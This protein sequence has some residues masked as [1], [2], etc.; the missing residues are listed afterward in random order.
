MPLQIGDVPRVAHHPVDLLLREA[1]PLGEGLLGLVA[2]TAQ[3]A[4]DMATAAP[5]RPPGASRVDGVDVLLLDL[6]EGFHRASPS[7][8]RRSY[9]ASHCSTVSASARFTYT[10]LAGHS[11]ASPP[12]K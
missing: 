12:E 1:A 9:S 6:G 4:G 10:L 8:R 7:A 2:C 11:G 3:D 5:V